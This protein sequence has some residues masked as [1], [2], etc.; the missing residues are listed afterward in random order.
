MRRVEV[1]RSS[2]AVKALRLYYINQGRTGP[3]FFR[4]YGRKGGGTETHHSVTNASR[5]L[6]AATVVTDSLHRT[7]CSRNCRSHLSGHVGGSKV[8]SRHAQAEGYSQ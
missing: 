7:V 5:H 1:R 3:H 2:A 6:A 8:M 4:C